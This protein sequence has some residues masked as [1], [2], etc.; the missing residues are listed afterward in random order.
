LDFNNIKIIIN[1]LF[2]F[3]YD[4]NFF[5]MLFNF[6]GFN[7]LKYIYIYIYIYILK[8]NTKRRCDILISY[9]KI[10]TFEAI[11]FEKSD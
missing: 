3:I 2:C 9:G 6:I 4:E 5:K 7:T 10:T 1:Y 8:L 11:H